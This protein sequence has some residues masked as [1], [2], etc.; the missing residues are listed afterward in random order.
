MLVKKLPVLYVV[1]KWGETATDRR[2]GKQ[3]ENIINVFRGGSAYQ[4]EY[5]PLIL[6]SRI[7]S[8]LQI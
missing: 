2:F 6:V 5:D 8:K 1:H 7:I 4:I 3:H